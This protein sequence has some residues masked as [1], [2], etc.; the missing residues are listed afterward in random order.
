M[1]S[2]APGRPH[3]APRPPHILRLSPAHG[4]AGQPEDVCQYRCAELISGVNKQ[5]LGNL[6]CKTKHFH[7][8]F[9]FKLFFLSTYIILS[10]A[11]CHKI[12]IADM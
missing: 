10:P 8:K 5:K 6:S 12:I 3:P 1:P 7:A 4:E 11:A 9:M 2:R